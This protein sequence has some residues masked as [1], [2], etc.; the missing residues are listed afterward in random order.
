MTRTTAARR[1]DSDA[2][3]LGMAPPPNSLA[4]TTTPAAAKSAATWTTSCT[5]LWM[6]ISAH[7]WLTIFFVLEAAVAVR[8]VDRG[9]D[10]PHQQHLGN[11]A[12][13]AGG[14]QRPQQ[15]RAPVVSACDTACQRI[16]EAGQREDARPARPLASKKIGQ[17]L[18]R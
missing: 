4:A 2:H 18:W 5:A 10:F 17:M 7:T 1:Y 12:E 14:H 9:L 8:D 15:N 3:A 6:S 11:A 13:Q 16:P